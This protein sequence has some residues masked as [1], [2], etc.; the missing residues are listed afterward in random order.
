MNQ[1]ENSVACACWAE[2]L[3]LL[4]F[5]LTLPMSVCLSMGNYALFEILHNIHSDHRH[6]ICSDT[7]LLDLCNT[8]M[9]LHSSSL[10]FHFTFWFFLIKLK[11]LVD[12]FKWYNWNRL[13]HI[14]WKMA[15][16]LHTYQQQQRNNQFD[17]NETDSDQISDEFINT[18]IKLSS[19]LFNFI[20]TVYY[21]N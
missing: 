10:M 12:H 15:R 3:L 8:S 19:V 6:I 13:K 7:P 17:E 14:V 21:Q 11:R 9:I 2:D 16:F 20:L 4:H 5:P 18:S 1:V